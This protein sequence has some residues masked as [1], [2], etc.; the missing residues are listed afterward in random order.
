MNLIEKITGNKTRNEIAQML[1][2]EK[3]EIRQIYIK[4]FRLS[5]NEYN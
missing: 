3:E 1:Y 4:S 5:I 2:D